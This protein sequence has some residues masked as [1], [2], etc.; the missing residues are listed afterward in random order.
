MSSFHLL[1][2]TPDREIY[3]G[4]ADLLTLFTDTGEMQVLPEHVSML[5]S[6]TYSAVRVQNEANHQDFVLRQGFLFVEQE[7]NDVR[8]LGMTIEKTEELDLISAKEYLEFI[9][10]KLDKPDE[11][12]KYQLT[13][14]EG[15][16]MALEKQLGE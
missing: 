10:S 13:F 3:K 2:Q 7:T 9:L 14:L 12:N 15:Q 5:G 6:I 1:I 16:K 4:P 8:V 11:L